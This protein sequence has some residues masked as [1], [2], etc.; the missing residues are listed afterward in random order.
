M[1]ITQVTCHLL[2]YLQQIINPPVR[3]DSANLKATE[4]SFFFEKK[5]RR[6]FWWYVS[7]LDLSFL[8]VS[9][10]V[11]IKTLFRHW[12]KDNNIEQLC[13]CAIL[14][15]G[16]CFDLLVY[17]NLE[18][19]RKE[20]E[21]AFTQALKLVNF[22][23]THITKHSRP[24]LKQAIVYTLAIST[25]LGAMLILCAYSVLSYHPIKLIVGRPEWC[26]S[27]PCNTIFEVGLGILS[28][29]VY[30]FAAYHGTTCDVFLLLIIAA[31]VEI[32]EVFSC[33]L[34]RRQ[35]L[36][37]SFRRSSYLKVPVN[38]TK[39]IYIEFTTSF[40]ESLKCYRC[41]Q[42]LIQVGNQA[43]GDFIQIGL[44]IGTSVATCSGYVLIKLYSEFPFA[45]YLFFSLIL[46]AIVI[47]IL[48]L[49]T[50]GS[51]PNENAAGFKRFWRW[52]LSKKEDRLW[53]SSCPS[54]GYSFGFV[55]ECTRMTAFTIINI[56]ANLIAT[57][58]LIRI[59]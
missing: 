54:I 56:L 40:H 27:L 37:D 41:I 51:I 30:T 1:E 8:A 59:H 23:L 55:V 28:G 44:I 24:N 39:S 11:R 52:R 53:L 3:F 26:V 45:V 22:K 46:P 33:N 25:I 18:R 35:M 12:K 36:H 32:I 10:A 29:V 13:I 43:A 48:V 4:D 42:I 5:S 17:R 50:L 38:Q 49:C 34:F 14:L 21:F 16:C 47:V 58:A 31:C 2:P 7:I 19:A 15:T 20:I 9:S 57:L 6:K